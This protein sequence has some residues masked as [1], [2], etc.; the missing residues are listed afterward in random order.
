[1]EAAG[2][3]DR[4][5]VVGGDVF[6]EVPAGADAYFTCTVLRC[7]EDDDCLRILKNIRAAMG[8][9]SRLVAVEQEVPEGPA[10]RPYA[11]LDLHAMVVYGSRDRTAEEYRNLYALAGLELTR[12]VPMGGPLSAFEGHAL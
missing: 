7:F 10:R 11:M 6:A 2:V 8:P 4:V 5:A 12:V 1:L 9:G 3:A